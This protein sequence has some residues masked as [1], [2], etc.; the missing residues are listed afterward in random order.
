MVGDGLFN[1]ASRTLAE[2]RSKT[3]SRPIGKT[4]ETSLPTTSGVID[5][6]NA[7]YVRTLPGAQTEENDGRPV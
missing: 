5:R 1:I 4:F 6:N 7:S 3:D 2:N